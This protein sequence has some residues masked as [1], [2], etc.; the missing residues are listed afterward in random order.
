[1]SSH[2]VLGRGQL[3]V[4]AN[5]RLPFLTNIY[6]RKLVLAL[7]NTYRNYRAKW[8][9]WLLTNDRSL[10]HR[11]NYRGNQTN[12]FVL[13]THVTA[14]FSVMYISLYTFVFTELK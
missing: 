2:A 8:S 6:R 14:T 7:L 13:L 1:M 10:Q 5:V 9:M 12:G 11:S 4:G 3:S